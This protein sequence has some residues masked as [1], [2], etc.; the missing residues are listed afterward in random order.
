LRATDPARDVVTDVRDERR[1]RC[2]REHGVERR[3]AIG[4]GR[5]NVEPAADVVEGA[6]ADP[7]DALLDGMQ[8]WKQQMTLPFD[9]AQGRPKRTDGFVYRVSLFIG[10]DGARD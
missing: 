8:G 9:E 10:S 2:G 6:G 4:L 7:T 3:D 1:A 5:R